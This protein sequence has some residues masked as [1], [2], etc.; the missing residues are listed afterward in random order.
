MCLRMSTIVEAGLPADQFALDQTLSAV[1]NATFEV[2]R[3]VATGS[4][5]VIPFVWGS[6]ADFDELTD[7]LEADPSTE[8]VDRLAELRE[9]CLFQ[10]K[11]RAHIGV[12]LELVVEENG[13]IMDARGQDEHWEFRILFPEHDSV[14]TTKRL[15][16][17]YGVDFDFRR[18]CPLS[19]S[20]R[21]GQYGLTDQ[22]YE[23][24]SKAFE[25]GY[26]DIP[27]EAHLTDLTDDVSHQALSERLRRGHRTLIRNTLGPE[28]ESDDGTTERRL[29]EQDSASTEPSIGQES[30]STTSP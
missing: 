19:E 17:D 2:V 30:P 18:V 11:W 29:T 22:Q 16:E 13:S 24:I 10:M 20:T 25:S 12:V 9:E 1:P 7:Q 28:I 8:E 5:E 27:R 14:S 26:Y 15:C 6:G 21:R 3:L 4:S 23:T